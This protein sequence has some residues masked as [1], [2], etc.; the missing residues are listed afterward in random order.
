LNSDEN[1]VEVKEENRKVNYPFPNFA[2]PPIVVPR[3]TDVRS[4]LN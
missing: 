3:K 4:L 1:V 2:G